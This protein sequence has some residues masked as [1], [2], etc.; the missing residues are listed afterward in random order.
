M[1]DH[2]L[3]TDASPIALSPG[4][5][6]G[7]DPEEDEEDPKEDPADYPVGGGD[8]EY[9]ES[10]DDDDDDDDVVKDEEEE[11]VEEH[12]ALADPSAILTDDL[13]CITGFAV[14]L[15]QSSSPPP[16]NI[17]RLKTSQMRNDLRM[18][19]Q[20][21]IFPEVFLEDL[22]GLPSTRQ[23]EFQI[24]LFLTLGNFSLVCHV[25]GW[26][27]LNMHRLSVTKQANGEESLSPALS[28]GRGYSKNGIQ[29][30]VWPVR[31][32]E[33]KPKNI[34]NEDVGGMLIEN[35]KDPE[36]LRT[37]KLEPHTDGTLC[38][39][40]SKL[41][42]S[43][44]TIWVIIDG[45]TKSAIFVP[46]RETNPMEKLARTYLKEVVTMH[47]IPLSIICDRD[48]MFAT[49]F[50]RDMLRACA[51][52]FEKGCVNHFPLVEF[53]YNNSYH[54]SIKAAPFEALYDQ[55]CR[56][57]GCWA[58]V[59]KVQFTDPEI[60]Q[61]TTEK[62]VQI[63]QRIQAARDRQKSYVDL[64]S[65]PME[66]Q[67]GDSVI[68]KCHA[69]EPL[70]VSLDGIYFDDKLHFVEEPIKIMDPE[71]KQLKRSHILIVKVRW[72]SRRGPGFTWE[73]EDQFQKKYPHLFTKT[74]P[75]PETPY[76]PVGYD[77]SNF[78]PRQR[79]DFCSLNNDHKWYDEL[80]D[81][82]LKE[83]ALMH[84]AEFEESWVDATLVVLKFCAW[85]NHSQGP[86]VNTKTEKDYDPYLDIDR[87][88]GRNYRANNAGDDNH[89]SDQPETSNTTPPVP[90][91]TQQIPQGLHKGYDRF[92]TLLS[93]LDIHGAG[94]SHEDANQ[95]FLSTN[96]VS[97]AYSVSSP[98]VS[99]SQKEGSSTYTYKVI[100]S[101]FENHTSAPQLDYND[102]EQIND[103][104]MEEID[105]KWQVAMI[106]MRIK[107][108]HKR[109]GRKLQ[110]DTKDP[111]GFDKT[112]V[113]C[114][115]CH[116]IGHFTRD[117]R[118]KG[119]QDH[120][121]RD[122]GY[123]GNKA[124]DNGRRPAYQDDSKALVTID[125]EDIDWSRHVEEDAQNYAVMAYYFSNS[126]S[127]TEVKSCSK[128]CEE[129][130]ARLKK[131]Y[132]EQRDKLGDASVEITAYT[133]ALKKKLL[134]KAL[135]EKEELKTKV[136]T[137]QNSSKNLSRLL[138]TQMSAN[139]K[140]GLGYGDYRYGSILSYEN[141]VLQSVFM[142]KESDLEN[143]SVNDRYADGMHEVP[144]P[145]I[146]N[147]MPSGPDVEINYSKFTYGPKQTLLDESDAKT[148]EH[149]SCE[150][151]F[152]VK[153]TTS[154]PALVEN[155]Q[156]VICKPKVWT[157]APIIEEYES[158][159]DSDYV[160]NVQ[161]DIEKP[162]FAF[163]EYVKHVKPSRENVKET[164]IPNH[165]PKVE[166]Q[167]RSGHT[168]KGLGYA[169][170]RKA[171]F[172]CGSFSH[173]IRECDFH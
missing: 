51:I 91:P 95:K 25:E 8:D 41:S 123:N 72:N 77:V 54:A 67:V 115:N 63:K 127:D 3:P 55:K 39:N 18:Y 166:K 79:T 107:K 13:A 12:L 103:D 28:T 90:S 73:H 58:K 110:F 173:L 135:K 30:S 14:V 21:D 92:Q 118:A 149:A 141:E 114:F 71:V 27:I 11:E 170:T 133:L 129:S 44:D 106:S 159:S 152:S 4:Y 61:E 68:L 104:D 6:T 81:G 124:R 49:N 164:S 48:P 1:E 122:D 150:S 45:L 93:Q 80:T 137:W 145:M 9:N 97:I 140:F 22:P 15:P 17:K 23:V 172:I 52:E 70:A 31:V 47:G 19:R 102:L 158:D 151:N 111:V 119:N 62:I 146:G 26:I 87:I 42:Q 153:T 82:K 29:N 144:P 60:V 56:S 109:T 83:E 34:K 20:F 16:E 161:E 160:S 136:E 105:L 169:F 94:V 46:M 10:S 37:K 113:E 59:G 101:F 142:N 132:D 168:R 130:Y 171:C 126:S 147:Y 121:R 65:K 100:H 32:P 131:L 154:M 24:D 53:S 128:T 43:Y 36:K 162:S 50:W 33:R 163:I 64:K 120:K 57:P 85:E 148:S 155:T 69:D 157:D 139:D 7:S 134:A 40:A 99:K 35:S 165:S 96:D 89:D 66:Y 143:T 76:P 125:G 112:K 75:L 5:I 117:C 108:F 156:K 116:K 86:Y 2:P 138:N 74:A 88:F 167:D 98:S 78:L 84:K 38:L